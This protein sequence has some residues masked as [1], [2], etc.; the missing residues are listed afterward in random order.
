MAR[1]VVLR[2]QRPALAC[3]WHS[4]QTGKLACLW[5]VTGTFLAAPPMQE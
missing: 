1:I 2:R 4:D 5:E 3:R